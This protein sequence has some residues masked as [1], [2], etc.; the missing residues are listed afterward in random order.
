MADESVTPDKIAFFARSPRAYWFSTNACQAPVDQCNTFGSKRMQYAVR[1]RNGSCCL[2]VDGIDA[3]SPGAVAVVIPADPS[4]GRW[5]QWFGQGPNG[6]R[7]DCV[8]AEFEIHTGQ[9]QT[10]SEQNFVFVVL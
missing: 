3:D 9:G 2:R 8:D 1:V 6:T 4:G 7:R 10:E 5:A